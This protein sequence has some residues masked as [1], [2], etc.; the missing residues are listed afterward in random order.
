MPKPPKLETHSSSSNQSTAEN[1]PHQPALSQSIQ[2]TKIPSTVSTNMVSQNNP[3][4]PS[5]M[6]SASVAT[7][8]Y[9]VQ[10]GA[11][12]DQAKAAAWQ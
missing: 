5:S 4:N 8:R 2:S 11:L 3:A 1:H 7:E 12:S 9:F 6:K 10:I